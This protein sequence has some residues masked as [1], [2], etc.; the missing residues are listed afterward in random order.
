MD[1]EGHWTSR[2]REWHGTGDIVTIRDGGFMEIRGRTENSINRCG[3]LVLL[4]DIENE[5]QK[6]EFLVQVAVVA[7][8]SE[9]PQ[10]QKL[11][12]CCVCKEGYL[13]NDSQVRAAISKILP[14]YAVPEDVLF[15]KTL[16]LLPNGKVDL[17]TLGNW[18]EDKISKSTH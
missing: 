14:N 18:A 8:Q 12:A 11:V 5:I 16:P 17:Q 4:S 10:G 2:A 6:L 1:D 7:T 3:Y 15:L 9:G 13:L